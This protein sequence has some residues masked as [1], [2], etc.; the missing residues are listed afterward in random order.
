MTSPIPNLL[1]LA[2]SPNFP[3]GNRLS[4]K[5]NITL[6]CDVSAP[7]SL[8]ALCWADCELVCDG[9]DMMTEEGESGRWLSRHYIPESHSRLF[10]GLSHTCRAIHITSWWPAFRDG[11]PMPITGPSTIICQSSTTGPI[12]TEAPE[13]LPTDQ[14]S[15]RLES[16]LELEPSFFLTCSFC[17]VS[18]SPLRAL[19]L[20]I[21]TH[22]LLSCHFHSVLSLFLARACL[23]RIGFRLKRVDPVLR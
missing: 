13:A 14:T 10:I 16:V 8:T 21:Y 1:T 15:S 12:F 5:R 20:S 6:E 4:S 11:R 17:S 23:F 7:A 2:S 22:F 18:L 9:E 3:R 19:I